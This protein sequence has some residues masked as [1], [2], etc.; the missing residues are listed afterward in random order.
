MMVCRR[1]VWKWASRRLYGEFV[2][3][4]GGI[5][6]NQS[7]ASAGLCVGDEFVLVDIFDLFKARTRRDTP[8]LGTHLGQPKGHLHWFLKRAEGHYLVSL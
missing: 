2:Q 4:I 1:A 7:D 3:E 6:T 5:V 8:Q